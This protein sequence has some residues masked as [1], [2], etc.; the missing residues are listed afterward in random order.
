MNPTRATI[1]AGGATIV[2]VLPML[3]TGALAVQLTTQLGFGAAGLGLVIASFRGTS[4]AAT[5][6]LGRV[7]DRLGASVSLRLATALS[8]ISGIGIATTA[9]SWGTLVAWMVASGIALA[10]AQPASNRLVVNAVP[11]ERQGLA[12]GLTKSSPPGASMLAGLSVPLIA[13]TVGWRYSYWI[14]AGLAVVVHLLIGRRSP[15][16]RRAG[17]IRPKPIVRDPGTIA[18]FGL[19]FGIGNFATAVMPAFYVTAAVRAGTSAQIAGTLLATASAA[20]ILARIGTGY[21]SDRMASGHL[22]LCAKMMAAGAV[23]LALLMTQQPGF[24]AAGLLIG[25]SGAWGLNS[26]FWFAVMRAYADTPG[27]TTGM[28]ATAGHGG[29]ALGPIVFG[30]VAQTISFGAAWAVASIMAVMAS[31][32]LLLASRRLEGRAAATPPAT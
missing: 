17:R 10:L 12:F 30:I 24:M 25:L 9:R 20:A 18:I 28:V 32:V 27:T 1:I 19:A 8:A 21:A 5:L 29:A 31:F 13:L 23:G 14:A 22:R 7:A 16:A 11:P 6:F 15:A 26:V 2:G 4:A 3:L